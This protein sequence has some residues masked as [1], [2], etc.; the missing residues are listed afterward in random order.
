MEPATDVS[1]TGTEPGADTEDAR[2]IDNPKAAETDNPLDENESEDA[3]DDPTTW[4][5]TPAPGVET[6][7]ASRTPRR[8]PQP[9]RTRKVCAISDT[10]SG[11]RVVWRKQH[12]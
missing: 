4:L 7:T 10:W 9:P 11:L 6:T 5:I 1:D 8:S 2:S 3:G 12:R